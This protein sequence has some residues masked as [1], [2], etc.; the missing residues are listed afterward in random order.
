MSYLSRLSNDELEAELQEACEEL[1][2]Y[3]D[4]VLQLENFINHAEA[5]IEKRKEVK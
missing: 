2:Y 3:E 1:E 5:E 4:K